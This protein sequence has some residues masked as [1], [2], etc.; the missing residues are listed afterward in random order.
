M[1]DQPPPNATE[2]IVR[3]G[4]GRGF[5][6][7]ARDAPL[8]LTAAH[9][10]PRLPPA[11]P[12]SH[13]EERTYKRLVGPLADAEP[14]LAA[15]CLFADP[16]SDVAILARPDPTTFGE[17]GDAFEAFMGDTP[18]LRLAPPR[19]GMSVWLL[20]LDGSWRPGIL[21]RLGLRQFTRLMVDHPSAHAPGTSGSPIL[22]SAGDAV[23][24]VSLGTMN[25]S[26]LD[27]LPRWITSR[28]LDEERQ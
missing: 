7:A 28:L 13:T 26:L 11:H 16:V 12:W 25:P 27:C 24:L 23:A 5:L 15:E 2:S 10:L 19:D 22:T 20:A 6:V 21:S 8:I 17:D 14:A 4:T 18:G 1:S 3:V 9:C